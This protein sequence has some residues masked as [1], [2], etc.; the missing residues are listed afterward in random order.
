METQMNVANAASSY[1]IAERLERLP[2]SPWHTKIRSIIAFAWFFDAYDALSIAYVLPAI[3]P[4]WHIPP[5]KIGALISIGYAGQALGALLF[6]YLAQRNG[7]VP[8]TIATLFMFSLMS[9]ACA[10]AWDYQSLFWIRFV[11]GIGLGG[12]IPVVN[13]YLAE[14]AKAQRRARFIILFQLA[15]P[16]GLLAAS[17]V[18]L[19][20]VPTIGWQWMFIIGAIPAL[21]AIP[22]RF[23]LPE[24]PRWLASRGRFEEADQIL[25]RIE[26]TISRNGTKQLPPIPTD[27]PSTVSE[28]TRPLD[29]LRGIYARR[30]VCVWL[31]WIATY[32]VNYGLIGWLPTIWGSVYHLSVQD[33]LRYGFISSAVGLA[34]TVL[35]AFLLD[36]TGRK[37]WFG[38]ALILCGL[39]LIPLSQGASIAPPTVLIWVCVSLFWSN[40]V[41]IS[42]G[43]F[44]SENYPTH[45]RALGLGVAGAWQRVASMV[46][47]L[48]VGLI[49]PFYGVGAVFVLFA[50][51]AI[52]G[53]V[54]C[55]VLATETKGQTLEQLSP[56][57]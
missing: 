27:L 8:V 41:A 48:L 37:V 55:F 25:R 9:L 43:V 14:F 35:V 51:V 38:T 54:S 23:L 6:G 45:L 39:A 18:G 15:F 24:S 57:K 31:L 26:N 5:Q 20:V 13:T 49:L 32:L 40:S 11:Q 17:G 52:L 19:L 2:L 33:A 36:W 29:L 21:L 53:G 56:T 12:E 44:T 4:L 22:L 28:A 47:P 30:T 46:G 7:R 16:I 34:A 50:I 3:V 10:F 42:L 1:R